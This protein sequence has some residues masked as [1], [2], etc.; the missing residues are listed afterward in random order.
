M[1][2]A[3]QKLVGLVEIAE[4]DFKSHAIQQWAKDLL[5]A[6]SSP[7]NAPNSFLGTL[8]KRLATQNRIYGAHH[9]EKQHRKGYYFILSFQLFIIYL[10]FFLTLEVKNKHKSN[11]KHNNSYNN[12][13]H[14]HQQHNNYGL[15]SK[16]QQVLLLQHPY[17]H[18][19]SQQLNLLQIQIPHKFQWL[20]DWEF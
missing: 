20:L 17:Q 5:A 12:N 3:Q 2:L 1:E 6:C 13:N 11:K 8:K 19:L 4:N 9:V 7:K 18:K 16:T 14:Q 10:I 15:G